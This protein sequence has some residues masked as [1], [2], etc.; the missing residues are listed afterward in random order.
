[1]QQSSIEYTLQATS[2]GVCVTC[3]FLDSSA[4]DCLVVVHQWISSSGLM[5]IESS[6]R[7][8][9]SLTG[10]TAYGCIEGI[11]LEHY[12]LGVVGGRRTVTMPYRTSQYVLFKIL[13][14]IYSSNI[15]VSASVPRSFYCLR[16]IVGISCAGEPT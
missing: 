5:N 9:R 1:M 7:F 8:N 16:C 15:F 4:T 3:T 14:T 6:H 10:D 2:T 12:Q 13:L 11:S